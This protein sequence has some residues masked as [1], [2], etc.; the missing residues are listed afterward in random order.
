M[1]VLI[2][3]FAIHVSR[4]PFAAEGRNGIKAPMNEDPEL[5]VSVPVGH[6]VF[7]KRLPISA[8]WTLLN[9]T[10]YL[11]QDFGALGIVLVACLSPDLID[12]L[13]ALGCSRSVRIP[14]GE[15]TC[16]I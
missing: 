8:K 11:F 1:L 10:V 5:R 9:S 16:C 3:A 15:H 12:R 6:F 2:R 7:L 13:W 14:T 4:I